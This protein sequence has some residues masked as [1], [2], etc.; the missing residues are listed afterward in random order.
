[1][2]ASRFSSSSRRASPVRGA[3][4][5]GTAPAAGLGVATA[6]AASWNGSA[7]GPGGASA[8][9]CRLVRG[10]AAR[11]TLPLTLG[12]S[13][14][15]SLSSVGTPSRELPAGTTPGSVSSSSRLGDLPEE[16]LCRSGSRGPS[17][18]SGGAA[19][20]GRSRESEKSCSS[21]SAPPTQC[22]ED[23][24]LKSDVL[25]LTD[26][27]R[28]SGSA[29]GT[30]SAPEAVR[31]DRPVGLRSMASCPS[32]VS[33]EATAA[34]LVA[35]ALTSEPWAEEPRARAAEAVDDEVTD[36]PKLADA[37]LAVSGACVACLPWQSRSLPR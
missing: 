35:L 5:A 36:L 17:V 24:L 26:R 20:T 12:I 23:R 33:E 30:G 18:A 34:D 6:G 7:G 16:S 31:E 37:V 15:S 21:W 10:E 29:A 8:C 28:A 22:S 3:S 4:C 19:A 9:G 25:A 14:A 2:P 11:V 32:D 27:R 13:S 1:M